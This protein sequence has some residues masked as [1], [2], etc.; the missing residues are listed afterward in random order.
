MS[1]GRVVLVLL[2]LAM[3]RSAAAFTVK[4]CIKT[5]VSYVDANYGEDYWTTAGATTQLIRGAFFQVYKGQSLLFNDY[6]GDGIGTGD[7][8]IACTSNFTVSS[9]GTLDL[10]LYS[11]GVV[12][13]NN[14]DVRD[15][16]GGQRSAIGSKYVST[17]GTYTVP[18]ATDFPVRYLET[19]GCAGRGGGSPLSGCGVELDWLRVFWDVH[20]NSG[21]GLDPSFTTIAGWL[22]TA[23]PWTQ[24]YAYNELEAEANDVAGALNTNWDA[25]KGSS[26]SDVNGV[27][28]PYP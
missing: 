16:D 15:T 19:Q 24:S 18:I 23:T 13:S 25:S 3:P 28:H 7:P 1:R 27:D 2:F 4:L 12:Q 21:S 26:G 14:L 9:A 6:L 5:D 10:Y 11:Y 17:G 22:D 8:G 20:T